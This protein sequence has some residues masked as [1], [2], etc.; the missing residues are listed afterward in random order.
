MVTGKHPFPDCQGF[1]LVFQCLLVVAQFAV[2]DAHIVV[3]GGKVGIVSG[4]YLFLDFQGFQ[5]KFQRLAMVA[6]FVVGDAHIVIGGGK[7]R[8]IRLTF[9]KAADCLFFM[10]QG[11]SGLAYFLPKK[12]G[13]EGPVRVFILQ[14]RSCLGEERSRQREEPE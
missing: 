5:L 9:L 6:H 11:I 2:G 3:G 7:I 4:K 12:S 10:L 13:I 14:Q 8:G 1:Q